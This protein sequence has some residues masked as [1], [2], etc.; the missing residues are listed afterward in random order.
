MKFVYYDFR[1]R[2]KSASI[3]LLFPEWKGKD[4]TVVIFSPHDD[5]AILGAGYLLLA[6]LE[7]GARVYVIIACDGRAG[8]SDVSCKD[9]IVRIRE[10][11]TLD[12]YGVLGVSQHH[13]VR[14][15]L[16]DFSAN[17]Y[18]G[19]IF[20]D[21]TEGTFPKTIQNL[22]KFR[23]TRVAVPN[24]YRE[25]ADHEAVARMGR[26]D[27]PQVGDDVL[28]D[29]GKP[30]RVATCLEYSVWADFSPEDAL[31]SGAPRGMRASR[32]ILAEK[33]VEEKIFEAVRKFKSQEK[34]IADL[35][36]ARKY[37]ISGNSALELYLE[38][39]PRPF[40]DYRPYW[41]EIRG[42]EAAK[43]SRKMN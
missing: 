10:A 13:I 30:C 6:A 7:N 41:R 38:I 22:R 33:V 32:A 15:G 8:Y 17:F 11:E 26:Y 31:V 34:V 43:R 16:P 12:A 5:D 39:D 21:K 36:N 35:V 42:M 19:W 4:E 3:D 9:D 25:H 27:V 29:W 40:L 24:Q 14:L 28:V 23:A 20:P 37:R 18:I 2:S 1:S